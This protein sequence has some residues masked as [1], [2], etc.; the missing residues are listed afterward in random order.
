MSHTLIPYAP[1]YIDEA[2]IG[3]LCALMPPS[4]IRARPFVRPLGRGLLTR[5]SGVG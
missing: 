2:E 4:G 5:W 3:C 1:G